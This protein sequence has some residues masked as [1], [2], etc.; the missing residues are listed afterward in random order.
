MK[1]EVSGKTHQGLVRSHNE[2]SLTFYVSPDSNRCYTIVADGMG[3]YRGGDVASSLAVDTVNAQLKSAILEENNTGI[4]WEQQLSDSFKHAN[5]A[6]IQERHNQQKFSQM[7]TTMVTCVFI[8]DEAT[9]AH[10]GDSRGYLLRNDQLSQIT[11]DDTLVQ[12]MIDEGSL[13]E[14]EREQAPFQNVLTKALGTQNDIDA[15]IY[16]YYLLDGDVLLFCSDG[17]TVHVCNEDI[18]TVITKHQIP[19]SERVAMLEKMA[20]NGG[21]Q[22]NITVILVRCSYEK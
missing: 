20:L 11:K 21:G 17:L 4:N 7:G 14:S 22:D 16:K 19:L 8:E 18:R 10:I 5:D 12:Q 15:S 9:I 2:D 3:G 1:F 13:K 6:I